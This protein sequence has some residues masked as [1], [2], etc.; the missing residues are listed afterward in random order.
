MGVARRSSTEI[1]FII[2]LV[3][4]LEQPR[5]PRFLPVGSAVQSDPGWFSYVVCHG[6][7]FISH[8]LG[9]G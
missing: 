7:G 9:T 5:G 3:G 6:E 8:G 4:G 1:G 2:D